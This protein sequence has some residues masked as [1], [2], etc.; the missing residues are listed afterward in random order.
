MNEDFERKP[1][2]LFW[3]IGVLLLIWGAI[4]ASMY[5]LEMTM[6]DADYIKTFGDEANEIRPL[7]PAWSI[8]G[9]AVGV[10]FGLLGSLL[11]LLRKRFAVPAYIISF[12]GALI[13]WGW[14]VITPKASAMMSTNGGWYMMALVI[15]LCLFSIWWSRKKA[16]DGT[17]S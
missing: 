10:W 11:L 7:I 3:I 1:G 2:A 16:A 4:G 6:S 5:V 15:F 9:Y 12:L 14:Y 8:A 17:L 13:G